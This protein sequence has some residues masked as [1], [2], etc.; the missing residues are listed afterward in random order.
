MHKYSALNRNSLI[1]TGTRINI[2]KSI[3]L[4]ITGAGAV[5]ALSESQW[6]TLEYVHNV[7]VRNFLDQ[8]A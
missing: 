1:P 2:L 5:W 3:L 8:T 4:C 6:K 7:G